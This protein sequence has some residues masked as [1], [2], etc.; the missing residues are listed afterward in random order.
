MKRTLFA[1][2]ALAG[3][4]CLTA[5]GSLAQQ[6]TFDQAKLIKPVTK[7]LKIRVHP[8]ADSPLV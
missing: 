1:R 5:Q 3:L 6:Y 4:L 2:M 8:E 7:T